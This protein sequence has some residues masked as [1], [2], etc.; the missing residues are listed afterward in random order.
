MGV[1]CTD[2][3][4]LVTNAHSVDPNTGRPAEKPPKFWFRSIL[5]ARKSP[6]YAANIGLASK[7]LNTIYRSVISQFPVVVRVENTH[8]LGRTLIITRSYEHIA[9]AL[10]REGSTVM[11]MNKDAGLAIPIIEK[12]VGYKP[13]ISIIP[14]PDGAQV[15]ER[16]Y[17]RSGAANSR[18]WF[19]NGQLVIGGSFVQ[20]VRAVF[21]W[22]REDDSAEK[23]GLITMQ[24]P[25]LAIAASLQPENETTDE[26]IIADWK[27][28]GQKPAALETA[29]SKLGPMVREWPGQ[30]T[31][32][33]YYS[34]CENSNLDAVDCLVT[35][36]D[37]WPNIENVR[38]EV[39]YLGDLEALQERAEALCGAELEA[40]H[41]MLGRTARAYPARALH[42]GNILPTGNDWV[43]GVVE[44]RKMKEGRPRNEGTM[45]ADEVAKKVEILGGVRRAAQIIGC[46]CSMLSRYQTGQRA[47]PAELGERLSTATLVQCQS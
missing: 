45:T 22:A 1:D 43:R 23:L 30:V 19:K 5:E 9:R 32:R 40:A 16:T 3:V 2:V 24:V 4:K 11:L 36:G 44:F 10:K 20:A 28:A 15:V 31:V 8:S 17:I 46:S 41:K 6:E 29:R 39:A 14:P 37:P 35:L 33:H 18:R 25:A 7:V 21:D 42:L 12:L 47:I 27:K 13:P 38:N 34:S 26:K